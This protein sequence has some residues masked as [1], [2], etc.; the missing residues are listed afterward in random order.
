MVSLLLPAA[1]EGKRMGASIPKQFLPLKGKPLFIHTLLAFEKH[2]LISSIVI[3][4]KEEYIPFVKKELVEAGIKKVVSVVK[5]GKTRQESV[6]QALKHAPATSEITLVHDAVR[7]FVSFSLINRVIESIKKWEGVIPA[8]PVRD[9]M[10]RAKNN[11]ICEKIEREGAFLV[12]TPQG[13]RTN[14]LKE[15]LE[16]AQKEGLLFT[17][18][19]TLLLHYKKE[20]SLVE[21]DF[22]NFKITYPQDFILAEHLIECKIEELLKENSEWK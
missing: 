13:F 3:A 8:L 5:G 12:Q 14:I 21:G 10:V 1:G 7:P 9:T 22:L 19:G 6:Y 2:P 16:M 20:V 17:D 11:K 15:C 4:T 18:E